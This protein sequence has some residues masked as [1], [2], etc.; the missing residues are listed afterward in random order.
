MAAPID[1]TRKCEMCGRCVKTLFK[2]TALCKVNWLTCCVCP[3][4][5]GR[6]AGPSWPKFLNFHVVFRKNWSNNIG[7][8]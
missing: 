2:Q 6:V 1:L 4:V 5:D 7:S 3:M 8:N